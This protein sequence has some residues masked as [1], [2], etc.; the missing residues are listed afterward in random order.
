[1]LDSSAL[2]GAATAFG[3]FPSLALWALADPA[4]HALTGAP[5]NIG[6]ALAL[7]RSSASSPGYLALPVLALLAL[8]TGAVILWQRRINRPG[9]PGSPWMDGMQPP[10]GL[11]FGEPAAQSV[12]DGFLPALPAIALPTIRTPALPNPR[13]PSPATALWLL[14]ATSGLFLLLT[15]MFG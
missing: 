1:M 8:A 4:I 12:G 14:L 2:S 15:A 11:P 10:V 9:K 7:L 13:P 3:I 6:P 5:P